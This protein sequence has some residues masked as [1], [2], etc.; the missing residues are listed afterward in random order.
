MKRLSDRAGWAM[1]GALGL[2]LVLVA[3]RAI[4]AGP[5]DPPGPVASTM[6]T[7]DDISPSWHRVLVANDGADSC[8]SSRFL[9]VMGGAAV[10]DHETGLVWEQAPSSAGQHWYSAVR[11]CQ[12][13]QIGGRYGWRLPSIEE[14]RSLLDGTGILPAGVF[15][16]VQETHYYWSASAEIAGP[17]P[18]ALM[19]RF[20]AVAPNLPSDKAGF[21]T[22][23]HAW[24]VRSGAGT[25]GQPHLIN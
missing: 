10:L 23:L 11:F 4:Q 1:A 13:A 16:N 25:E 24:C 9:C 19:I 8:H 15:S 22:T 12:N 18:Q 2:M 5:L 3:A 14:A 21:A 20:D 6:K 17:I 7:L